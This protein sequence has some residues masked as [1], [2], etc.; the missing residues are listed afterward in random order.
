M[1]FIPWESLKPKPPTPPYIDCISRST[2]TGTSDSQELRGHRISSLVIYSSKFKHQS[3]R[4]TLWRKLKTF[5]PTPR[6]PLF[7]HR[8]PPHPSEHISFVYGKELIKPATSSHVSKAFFQ[9]NSTISGSHLL[10]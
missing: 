5:L 2:Q 1:V 8:M 9:G 6:N 4:E 3:I 10:I 7:S